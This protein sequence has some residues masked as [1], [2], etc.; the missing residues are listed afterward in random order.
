MVNDRI[1]HLTKKSVRC[2]AIIAGATLLFLMLVTV[3]A[4]V[5]RYVFNAPVLW[6]LDYARVGLVVLVFLGLGY[7]GLTG[8]HIAVDFISVFL[9]FKFWN[10]VQISV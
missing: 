5:M 1:E 8:G 3:Y 4:V 10:L 9:P 6:A 7:C 2:L